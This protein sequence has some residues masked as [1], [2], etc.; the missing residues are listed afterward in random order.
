MKKGVFPKIIYYIFTFLLGIV[1]AFTLPTIFLNAIVVPKSVEAS[2]ASG[3]YYSAMLL[4]GNYFYKTPACSIQ[5]DGGGIVLYQAV[6]TL[7][8][9]SDEEDTSAN[10]TLYKTYL[11]FI[12]GLEQMHANLNKQRG[13][14]R[15][16]VMDASG[17]VVYVELADQDIYLLDMQQEGLNTIAGFQ[18][19]DRLDQPLWSSQAIDLNYDSEYFQQ[20]DEYVA[21]FNELI[22]RLNNTDDSTDRAAIGGQ[23][24]SLFDN[25]NKDYV[26]GEGNV[27]VN[28]DND[29]YMALRKSLVKKADSRATVVIVVYF[30]GIYIIADFLLGSHYIIKFFR[31]FLF[32][33][34]KVKPKN[35]QKLKTEE[36][37]GHDYYSTVTVSL[38][39]ESVP[40]F[41]ESVQIRYTNSDAEV[42]FILLKENDYTATLR[43]KAGTYVNPFVDINRVYAPLDLPDNLEVEGYKM[44]LKVKIIKRED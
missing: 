5:Y 26:K 39:L 19:V 14:V 3:D 20:F 28:A 22:A 6:M 35:K 38:D 24:Q 17:E 37:F 27:I 34:C 7:S 44:E 21:D 11:G 40:D 9:D 13:E 33:V 8:V 29:E 10:G 25:F 1:L 15:L 18:L 41:N 16:A 36:I 32:K 2:L 4:T 43:I 31:W 23:L 42:V 12:Y 30:V